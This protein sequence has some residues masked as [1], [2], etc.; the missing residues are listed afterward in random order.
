MKAWLYTLASVVAVSALSLIGV[1]LLTQAR[2]R[3]N[4]ITPFLVSFAAGTLLGAALIHLIPEAIARLGR[5][6]R[7]SFGVICGFAAFFI[8]EKFLR[9]GRERT[10]PAWAR[11]LHPVVPLNLLGDAAHNFIDGVVI[12]ASYLVSV[13]LGL[14][15]TL[16]VLAHE[17]PQEFGD[18]GVLVYGGLRAKTA[19]L[20]NLGSALTAVVGAL[21]SLLIGAR[22]EGYAT[23]LL[24][25]TAG[26]FLYIAG[27]NLVPELQRD[28]DPRRSLGQ[29]L[30]LALG[31]LAMTLPRLVG[32]D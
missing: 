3:L 27:S 13:S 31:T 12:G 6:P 30:F 5:G 14:A 22:V 25:V 20:L 28:H 23:L 1:V 29:F 10:A 26:V 7:V 9:W 4:K 15:T 19:L 8:L 32:G 17:L 2:R 21:I 18:F 16:A 24:P 11:R